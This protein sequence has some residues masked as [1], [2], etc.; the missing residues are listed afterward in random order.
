MIT[1]TE[2]GLG[3]IDAIYSSFLYIEDKEY[4][5]KS[6]ITENIIELTQKDF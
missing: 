6:C 1:S 4:L 5:T 3:G 2:R